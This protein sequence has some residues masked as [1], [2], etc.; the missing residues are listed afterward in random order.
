MSVQI[1]C[2]ADA[3]A[4]VGESPLWDERAEALWWSDI[5]GRVLHRYDPRTGRDEKIP[6]PIR[7]GTMALREKGGMVL[8]AEHGFWFF[9][10]AT[11]QLEHILDVEADRPD[12]RMND[13]CCD[14]QGRFVATSMNLTPERLPT[15]ACWRLDSDFTVTN[16]ADGLKIGNGVAFSPYGEFFHLADTLAPAIWRQPYA[17]D[18]TLGERKA[19]ADVSELAGKPDGATCDAEGFYWIAGVYGGELYR[20]D[21][22]GRL[23]RTIT[24]PVATPTCLRFGGRDLDE[25]YVTSMGENQPPP[26]GGLYVIRGLGVRGLPAARFAA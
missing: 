14:R 4:V 6:M 22:E 10:P 18:G 11:G 1:E 25:L 19:F 17:A 24:V 2:V 5:K 13:G 9:E 3:R 20:F 15:A 23:D 8:A 21:P 7:V 16:L 12:N 26:A